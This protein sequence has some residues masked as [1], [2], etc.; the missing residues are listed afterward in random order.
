[1]RENGYLVGIYRL[2]GDK[3]AGPQDM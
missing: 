2:D 1:M 3:I